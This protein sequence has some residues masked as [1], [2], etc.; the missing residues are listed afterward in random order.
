L[1]IWKRAERRSE[2][3]GLRSRRAHLEVLGQF[4]ERAAHDTSDEASCEAEPTSGWARTRSS[5]LWRV[6]EQRQ[7]DRVSYQVPQ[8]E[9][10]QTGLTPWR[11]RCT[12][13]AQH[14]NRRVK[15]P[16]LTSAARDAGPYS[17]APPTMPG[18]WAT[19]YQLAA[20][21]CANATPH[22][23]LR[24]NERYRED[25]ERGTRPVVMGRSAE[26]RTWIKT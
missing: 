3:R 22:V 9:R 14:R 21:E 25:V 4:L 10:T 6:C 16:N 18:V 19:I 20:S 23:Q 17:P 7:A 1:A 5:A 15:R 26:T 24:P 8:R 13:P 12:A 11:A 2:S